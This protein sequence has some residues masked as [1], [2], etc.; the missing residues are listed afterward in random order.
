MAQQ[1]NLDSSTI[2]APNNA[3]TRIIGNK[4]KLLSNKH[5]TP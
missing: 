5:K 1:Q 3:I 4:P 2:N